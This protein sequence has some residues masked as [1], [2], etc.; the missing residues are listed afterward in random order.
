MHCAITNKLL[1]V[2]SLL[3]PPPAQV[4]MRLRLL[5]GKKAMIELGAVNNVSMI[6][7]SKEKL[8][9]AGISSLLLDELEFKSWDMRPFKSG[10][11]AVETK[12]DK[13]IL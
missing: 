5:A 13:S 1:L 8:N 10:S 6:D 2:A 3:A 9:Q 11:E 4:D 12:I 7:E